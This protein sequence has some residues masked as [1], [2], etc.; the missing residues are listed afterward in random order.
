MTLLE[1]IAARHSVRSYHDRPLAD[2]ARAALQ[3]AIARAN[4]E[5]GLNIQLVENDPSA[6]A[7]FLAHY[8]KFRGVRDYLVLAGAK[9]PDLDERIGYWGE[10]LVLLAQTLGLNTCW[11]ALT[12]TKNAERV[13]LAPG[14]RLRC[15][16][17]LGYGTTQG[18]G[19][20]IKQYADVV[21]TPVEADAPEWFR[22]GVEAALLAPTAV[23]QQK[24]RFALRPDGT[25]EAKARWG[26]YAKIDLGIVKYHF[27]LGAAPHKVVWA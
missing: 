1:A 19:H 9:A 26:F 17:S 2:D 13:S 8:G 18:A 24:F 3:Q 4:A 5:G 27:E 15:V 20:R 11:V 16:I 10:Q 14:D 23:N 6:F 21:A 7:G 22:C 25:V 12:Y